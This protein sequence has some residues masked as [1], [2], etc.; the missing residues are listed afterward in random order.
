MTLLFA[1]IA[2]IVA[3]ASLVLAVRLW[4]YVSWRSSL[5]RL[6]LNLPADLDIVAL[7]AWLGSVAAQTHA[8]R[9]AVVAMPPVV[10]ETSA[11]AAGIRHEVRVP[12]SLVASVLASLRA[13]LPGVRITAAPNAQPE[14]GTPRRTEA[15]AITLWGRQRQLSVDKAPVLSQSLLA[16]LQ[17]LGPNE[18]VRWQWII[19]GAGTPPPVTAP[20]GK[21]NGAS[22]PWWLEGDA[23]ADADTIR[24]AR[25]KQREP[26]LHVSGRLVARAGSR[27][28]AW[29]LFGR[30][31]S[32]IR[33]LNAPGA[34]LVRSL[35]P[36]PVVTLQAGRLWWPLLRW[37]LRVSSAELAGLLGFPVSE[38]PLPGL[39]AS[40]TRQ[41][42][43]PHELA[44]TGTVLADSFYPDFERP[45]A[46]KRADRLM[47]VA[48]LGPTGTGKSTAM[49]NMALQDAS[50]GDGLAVLDPKADMAA[51]LLARLS[52]ER[53]DDVI[54]VNPADT[55]RPVGFNPLASGDSEA[56]RELAVDHVLHVFRAQWQEFW[57]PRTDA[58]LR[59]GLLVLA[60][61]KAADGTAFTVCELPLLL[62]DTRFRRWVTSQPGTPVAVHDFFQWFEALSN[63]ERAQV[64]GPVLNKLTALTQ[65][66]PLRLLLGQSRGVDLPAILREGKV[67][68]MPLSRGLVG[69]ETAQLLASLMTASL[70][71]ASLGRVRVPSTKRRPFWLF[72]DEAAEVVRLPLDLADVMSEARGLGV[73]LTLATQYLAQLPPDI[74]KA[75]LA[76]VRSQVIFQVEYDDA[77]LLARS[78][79]PSLTA[80]D[81]RNLPAYEVA[82]RLCID[83]RTSRPFTGLTRPLPEPLRDPLDLRVA[84][85][86]RYGVDRAA[87]EAALQARRQ[88]PR[89]A[90]AHYGKR[91]RRAG[92][93]S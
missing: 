41:V 33:L 10:I 64:V 44:R 70:W 38:Q 77:K 69:A 13:T 29:Q 37:P 93:A 14:Q 59:A 15:A 73:G 3:I 46:L 66:T 47:H 19:T 51:D 61:T 72:I 62:T 88:L 4:S 71:Q 20:S 57:G 22:L 67:L 48:L 7:Q 63:A 82:L 60:N 26:L 45:L 42:P 74:R 52:A 87:V 65:R 35:L 27:Q 91:P 32:P 54:V 75:L 81:L 34:Q 39:P 43:P 90:E 17:P 79:E 36:S 21:G 84:S 23:P 85:R 86:E 89:Q 78:F 12:Q 53:Q 11:T 56:E 1:V 68:I 28:R 30:A 55:G 58:V 92:G 49:I 16:A 40:L 80:D 8:Q 18:S 25:L 83:G 76:T 50:A 6:G 9:G 31:W 5:Q 2:A 24:S